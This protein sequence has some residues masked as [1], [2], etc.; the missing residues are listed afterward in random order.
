MLEQPI[1]P[2]GRHIPIVAD[3]RSDH[4]AEWERMLAQAAVEGRSVLH[5]KHVFESLTGRVSIEH[6]SEN[7]FGSLLPNL[8]WH[9]AK[10]F[11]D[12]IA[13]LFVLPIATPI[14]LAIVVWI[15]LDSPGPALFRQ[16]RIGAGGRPFTI[17]KF[18]TMTLQE[19][20]GESDRLA[21]M[22]QESDVRVT[23]VGR[24][25]RRTRLDELPQIFNII[26]GDMSWIGPRPEVLSLSQWYNAEIPFYIYRHIVRPGITGWAQV[27][28]GHVTALDAVH[29]KLQF[30]FYYIKNFSLWIDILISIKTLK[31]LITGFGAK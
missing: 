21:A 16:L 5:S 13:A 11:V 22:T 3:F 8:A 20:A 19:T 25:L 27:N 15:R 24:W 10:R 23:C 30:D 1:L 2:E 12:L 26:A 7:N 18:R 31:I 9:K 17:V 4:E 29:R 14:L 28:Q 6:L